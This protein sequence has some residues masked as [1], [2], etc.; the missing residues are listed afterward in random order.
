[1]PQTL[2]SEP[3][4]L[5]PAWSEPFHS[6]VS[7]SCKILMLGRKLSS[8]SGNSREMKLGMSKTA[9]NLSLNSKQ[10]FGGMWERDVDTEVDL[11]A[12]GWRSRPRGLFISVSS[13]QGWR[14][15]HALDSASLWS[16]LQISTR[17][18]HWLYPRVWIQHQRK[19]TFWLWKLLEP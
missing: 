17:L 19:E 13:S 9:R 6:A 16:L 8:H 12:R 2:E 18:W 10:K 1:M 14:T 5:C 4:L 7:F 11:L 15:F 3:A